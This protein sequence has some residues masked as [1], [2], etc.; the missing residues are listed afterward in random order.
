ML[1]IC[2]IDDR[3]PVNGEISIDDTVPICQ[4]LL[5][6]IISKNTWDDSNVKEL[7]SKL[8]TDKD[9]WQTFAFTSPEIYLNALER[10]FPKPDIIVF[11]WEYAGG[12]TKESGE[13]L[14]EILNS[15]FVI[16]YVYTGQTH[17]P[18]V[19]QR[20]ALPD[21]NQYQ[22][23]RL[24]LLM[25][26]DSDSPS[27]LLR[28]SKEIYD[29]NFSFKFGSE[30]RKASRES[31]EEILV[32]LGEYDINFIKD[33]LSEPETKE[34]DIKMLLAEKISTHVLED[35]TL[36]D[37]LI[38]KGLLDKNN[39]ENLLQLIKTKFRDEIS[40]MD[41]DFG[42]GSGSAPDIKAL[43]D[44]WSYR[45][46]YRPSDNQVRKGDIIK[47]NE[48]NYYLVVTPDCNLTMF[49]YKN[50]GFINL[51]PLWDIVSQSQEIKKMLCLARKDNK[52]KNLIKDAKVTSISNK[53]NKFPDG[54]FLLPY[55]KDDN[56]ILF[57]IGFS[58]AI[59]SEPINPKTLA[60]GETA[61]KR[62]K[63][64]LDYGHWVKYQRISTISEPFATPI[65]Q[66]AFD[67][68]LGIDTPD[69][70]THVQED[71]KQQM[72]Q[73]WPTN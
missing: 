32:K 6:L 55:V 43:K 57:L 62:E 36:L 39:A 34:T 17:K 70:N 65:I 42:S 58:K 56:N 60:S 66:S 46:Y 14:L 64:S 30:L 54:C 61:E 71:I 48:G 41:I 16:V 27:T 38:T 50:F 20:I 1:N 44:L 28:Q 15:S 40:S 47:N 13:L 5:E 2:V 51:I 3:I 21:L 10:D 73:I 4:S 37:E 67:A 33:F 26:E 72:Q 69:F 35:K 59:T 68:T 22:N 31:I 7:I 25:K 49:W 8:L 18:Q 11:D 19:E 63:H 53:I 29:H 24:Y 23:K 12:G 9:N 45:L 52:V